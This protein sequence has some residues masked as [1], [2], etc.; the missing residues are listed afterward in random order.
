MSIISFI[1]I[2]VFTGWWFGTIEISSGFSGV[3]AAGAFRRNHLGIAIILL[4]VTGGCMFGQYLAEDITF[5]SSLTTPA[6]SFIIAL[7]GS[8]AVAATYKISKFSSIVYGIMGGIMGWKYYASGA[9]DYIHI[10][11]LFVTWLIVPI[12][13]ASISAVLY[14]LYRSFIIKS[15]IHMFMLLRFL[16]ICLI[17]AVVL[18]ALSVG[19]NNGALIMVLNNTIF[20]GFDL[21]INSFDI[22]EQYILFIFS[23]FIMALVAWPKTFSKIRE[24]AKGEFDTNIESSVIILISATIVL[25]FFSLPALS[26]AIGLLATPLS[27]SCII[28]GAFMG[29]FLVKKREWS[30][31]ASIWKVIASIVATPLIGFVFTYILLRIINPDSILTTGN[32]PSAAPHNIINVTP[33]IITILI[34][35]FFFIIFMYIKKQKKIREQAENNLT[36]NQK[37]LFENQKA[38]SELEIKTVVAENEHLNNKLDLRRK[39]LINIALNISEQKKILEDLYTEIKS[40]REIDNFEEQK[41]RIEKIEKLLLHKMNFSQEVE[42]FYAQ[43][44]RLHKDFSLRLAEKHPHLTEQEKRLVTL[45]RLGFSSKHIASLMNIAT[46]SVEIS[47]YRL[48]SKLG[49][50]RKDNLIQFIKSI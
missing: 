10:S 23:V 30:G 19:M 34:L 11:K 7:G 8:L 25:I 12:L 22:N 6:S 27:I 18:F 36:A 42:S 39:E 37:E 4:I 47:R 41:A 29:V 14:Y 15:N 5:V 31:Y 44:E 9:I 26:S 33:V 16:R 21:S 24:M 49:L 38:I 32:V 40:I 43:I 46:K 1:L 2:A 13:A 3:A 45:L 28:I 20:P 35:F 48:R 50:N 17:A